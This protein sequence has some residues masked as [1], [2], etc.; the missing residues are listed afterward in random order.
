M[1]I[2]T[3]KESGI[4]LKRILKSAGTVL[5]V[6]C[7]FLALS[8][9]AYLKSAI[10]NFTGSLVGNSYHIYTY[11]NYGE[12]TMETSGDK[13]SI[14]GNQVASTG[15]DSEGNTVTNYDL[16]SVITITIDGYEIESCGDTC[17]FVQDGLNAEVDFTEESIESNTDGSLTDNASIAR[18]LNRYKN[19]FGKSRVVVIKSQLGQPITAYSGDEVYWEIPDDIPKCT[20]LMID[21]KALYIHRANFQIIDKALLD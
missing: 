8:G 9:C 19:A 14:S 17:I 11:D 20:K 1:S 3:K 6:F 13:I 10:N 21:G 5:L 16:S 2:M 18:F 15:V 7:I 4:S 12:L